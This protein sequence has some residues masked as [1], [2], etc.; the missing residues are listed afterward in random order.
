MI[1]IRSDEL[2]FIVS[3][4]TIEQYPDSDIYKI[5]N[6]Q[7]V[8]NNYIF[9]DEKDESVTLYIDSDPEIMKTIIKLMRGGTIDFKTYSDLNL[10]KIT[11]EKLKLKFHFDS[12]SFE[13]TGGIFAPPSQNTANTIEHSTSE[14]MSLGMGSDTQNKINALFGGNRDEQSQ[15]ILFSDVDKELTEFS[16]DVAKSLD[17]S[18]NKKSKRSIKPKIVKLDEQ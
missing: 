9:K 10:L 4:E 17:V 3:R 7:N 6:G 8:K 16:S 1:R 14:T 5:V 18:I 12:E 11:S 15:K 13:Q 2:L